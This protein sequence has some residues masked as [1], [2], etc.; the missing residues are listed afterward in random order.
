MSATWLRND[1]QNFLSPYIFECEPI[2]VDK[3][4]SL[5]IKY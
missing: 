1:S 4:Q 3:L 2:H 5:I